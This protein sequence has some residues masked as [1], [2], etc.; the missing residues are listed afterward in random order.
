VV[1]LPKDHGGHLNPPLRSRLK[2]V[3]RTTQLP[4]RLWIQ[5]FV[6][7]RSPGC[8]LGGDIQG[9]VNGRCLRIKI[10]PPQVFQIIVFDTT[11]WSW[12]FKYS[13]R[14]KIPGLKVD[15]SGHSAQTFAFQQIHGQSP[16]KPKGRAG[17]HARLARRTSA[18]LWPK[19][20]EKCER[21]MR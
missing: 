1:T 6:P 9:N 16:K 2:N 21:L 20:S 11:W 5:F 17:S 7:C 12:E 3:L 10:V 18:A 4:K 19:K 8:F 15:F 14:G 13:R